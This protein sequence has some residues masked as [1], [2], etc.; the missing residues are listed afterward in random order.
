MKKGRK[1]EECKTGSL[2]AECNR[3]AL[4]VP[5]VTLFV[6]KPLQN[7]HITITPENRWIEPI[8]TYRIEARASSSSL[9][10][11]HE[12]TIMGF[13]ASRTSIAVLCFLVLISVSSRSGH[14]TALAG[15]YF[16]TGNRGLDRIFFAIT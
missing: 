15:N 9:V 6:P 2:T 8:N 5:E 16:L 13:S 10:L 12:G 4:F 1:D 3:T 14:V 11:P 7:L